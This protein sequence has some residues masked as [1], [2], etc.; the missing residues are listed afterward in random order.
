MASHPHH[1]G[2][3]EPGHRHGGLDHGG[4]AVSRFDSLAVKVLAAGA[5]LRILMVLPAI[6]LLW[7]AVAW[8]LLGGEG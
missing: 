3:H 5:G 4:Q 2:H 8:A 7:A 6:A 1:H